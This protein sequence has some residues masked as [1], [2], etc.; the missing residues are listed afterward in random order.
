MQRVINKEISMDE[1]DHS[2]FEK[3]LTTGDVPA[4]ELFIRTSGEQRISNFYIW[5]LAYTEMY[6]S[7][8]YWPEF[9]EK[10][11]H[12]AM[13]A[14]MDRERRFGLTSEQIKEQQS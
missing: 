8:K 1:I 2:L 3:A 10:D 5:Q 9:T 4:P 11:L 6:F 7:N 13:Q 14:Y 12:E